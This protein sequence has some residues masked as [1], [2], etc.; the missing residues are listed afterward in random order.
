MAP[1]IDTRQRIVDSA[2]EL[3]HASS[4]A[5]VGVQAIC[6][7]AGVQKGSFYH[8]FPS[9]RDLTLAVLDDL[10]VI[11][12]ELVMQKAFARDVPPLERVARLP[13]VIYRMQ[14]EMKDEQGHMLGC[15]FGNLSL[16][17]STQDEVVRRRLAQVFEAMTAPIQEALQEAL[18]RGEVEDMDPGDTA[19]AMLAYLEGVM[20]T[21]KTRNDPELIRTLGRAVTQVHLPA[22]SD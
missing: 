15:P 10:S 20:L 16:E 14:R 6:Q 3:F 11:Y 12:R 7:H 9:K 19:Q 8:F 21:A 5:D 2:R 17:L 18:D 4:Y 1:S 22:R 13:L